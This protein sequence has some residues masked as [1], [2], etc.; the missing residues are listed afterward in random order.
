MD[1]ELQIA[2]VGLGIAVVAGIIAY[3]K[4]QERKHR[5]HAERAFKSEHR[6]VL[7]EPN[8][9]QARI[10]PRAG[11]SDDESE[12]EMPLYFPSA[13]P[14]PKSPGGRHSTPGVPEGVDSRID[15]F[16]LIESIEPLEV[17]RLWT[18]QHE[19]LDGLPRAVRWFA[20]HDG[21]NLWREITAHS[22][23]AYHWFCAAMQTVDRRGAIEEQTF[24]AFSEGVQR[25]AE[26][27]LAVPS[28]VPTRGEVLGI[29]AEMDKFCATVDVQ[30]GINLISDGEA[31]SG[32]KIRS[33]AEAEGMVLGMDGAFHAVDDEGATLFVLCNQEPALFSESEMRYLQTNGLTLLIDIPHVSDGAQ[34]F[35]RMMRQASHMARVLDGRIVDDNRAP[36]GPE[37]AEFIRSQ[38]RQYQTAMAQRGIPAGGQL[39]ARLFSVH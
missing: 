6:D 20:F 7:L 11:G 38:I 3:N 24:N 15:C 36:F 35:D 30:V 9:K 23:G 18:A 16:I 22:A 37:A 8:E 28:G 26:Q 14:S 2:L 10:E 27:F 39:A 17:H 21:E 1:S 29:A 31:F 4:W 32:T 12:E 33:L 13:A 5:K 19:Q 25:V 34:V